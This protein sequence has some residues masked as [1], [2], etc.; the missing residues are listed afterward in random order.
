MSL[1]L[2]HGGHLSHGQNN[3]REKL[4]AGSIYFEV[5]NYAINEKTGLI[6]YDKLE[7]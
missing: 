1:S 4:S 5:L 2:E 6:N 3:K 7:E